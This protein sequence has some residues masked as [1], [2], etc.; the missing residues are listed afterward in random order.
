MPRAEKLPV[1]QPLLQRGLFAGST[2]VQADGPAL[3]RAC[4]LQPLPLR[5]W[6]LPRRL[7]VQAVGKF[8][9]ESRR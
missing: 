3:G 2:P 8:A 5:F 7:L 4:W 9:V 1:L 6:S